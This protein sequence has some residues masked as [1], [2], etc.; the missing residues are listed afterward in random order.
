[1]SQPTARRTAWAFGSTPAAFS[2]QS[3]DHVP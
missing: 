2:A 3:A 1:M